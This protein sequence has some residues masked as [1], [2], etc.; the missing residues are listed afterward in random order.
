METTHYYLL[1][2]EE[3]S[4]CRWYT[5]NFVR[6]GFIDSPALIPYQKGVDDARFLFDATRAR[7]EIALVSDEEEKVRYGLDSLLFIIGRK[8]KWMERIGRIL[9][10]YAFFVLLYKFVSYNRK[11]I[12][13]SACNGNCS[14]DPPF[15]AFWRSA[16]IA[17]FSLLSVLVLHQSLAFDYTLLIF[18]FALQFVF[19][20]T[21]FMLVDL[22]GFEKYTGVLALANFQQALVIALFVFIQ[23]QFGFLSGQ[24]PVLLFVALTGFLLYIHHWNTAR[25]GISPLLTL[26]FAIFNLLAIILEINFL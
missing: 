7:A 22:P 3:C 8:W 6:F 21:I 9:P 26:S 10:V 13:P 12:A 20:W 25:Q 16:F 2:D 19:Q 11:I 14:C 5:R 24:V 23:T 17:L 4:L 1:Y 18:H 15:S